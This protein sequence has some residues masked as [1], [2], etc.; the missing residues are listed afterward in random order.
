MVTWRLSGN[1]GGTVIFFM[2]DKLKKRYEQ[3]FSRQGEIMA[4]AHTKNSLRLNT[5][6]EALF[7]S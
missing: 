4:D 5:R 7:F 3:T 6:S 2:P 1:S